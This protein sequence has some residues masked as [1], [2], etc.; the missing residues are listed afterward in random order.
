[1]SAVPQ[2]PA[3]N[4]PDELETKEWLDA[5]EA[6]LDREGAERAHFLL[7]QLIEKARTS[8]AYIPFSPNTP[9]VNTIPPHME[10]RSPGDAHLEERIRFV[11]DI[12]RGE[13]RQEPRAERER[14]S[15]RQAGAG[16]DVG[17][18][19][20]GHMMRLRAGRRRPRP[21]GRPYHG[22]RVP[23]ARGRVPRARGRSHI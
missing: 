7:E 3:A 8:G 20:H 9:Y 5:L 14:R 22:R 16:R 12:A 13:G 15:D 19:C 4:D 2:Q 21:G 1:M 11:A 18:R 6:V 23:G 17:R 10:A